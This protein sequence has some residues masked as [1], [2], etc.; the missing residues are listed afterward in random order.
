MGAFWDG[1][2]GNGVTVRHGLVEFSTEP[3][4]NA[5]L[6]AQFL[7]EMGKYLLRQPCVRMFN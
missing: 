6:T 1:N 5:R 2:I 3:L 7:E 4:H